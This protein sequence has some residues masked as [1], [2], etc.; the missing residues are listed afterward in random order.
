M[1]ACLPMY[2]WPEQRK[3]VDDYWQKIRHELKKAD[4]VSPENLSRNKSEEQLWHDENLLL[5]QTCGYPFATSLKGKVQYVA[6]PVYDVTGC[7]GPQYSS[8][9]VVHNT[10]TFDMKNLAQARFAYNSPASLSGYRCL[11][12]LVGNPV[13]FFAETKITGSHRLSAR[14]VAC[15]ESDIAALDA[16]C[17]ELLKKFEPETFSELKIL[18]WTKH[19]P[20]LPMITSLTTKPAA[21]EVLR[22]ILMNL[23]PENCLYIEGY[24]LLPSGQYE[25]LAKF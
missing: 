4:M 25:V 18:S 15:Q 1:I 20:A 19:Y 22:D 9:L 12:D 3:A 21:L 17:L 23:A 8:A 10:S 14:R 13:E 11:S 16:V 6:T 24:E 7:T 2:D 5:G